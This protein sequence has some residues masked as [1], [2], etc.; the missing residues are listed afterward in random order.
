[1]GHWHIYREFNQTADTLSNHAIDERDSN[2]F[3]SILVVFY[4]HIMF[5][6]RDSWERTRS[7]AGAYPEGCQLRL[8]VLGVIV[9]HVAQG[10]QFAV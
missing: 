5:T 2:C 6:C 1:M 8:H 10:S 4:L 9:P 7:P 3:F